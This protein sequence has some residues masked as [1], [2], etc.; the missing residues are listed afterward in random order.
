MKL[1]VIS[2][3]RGCSWAG[4]ETVWHLAT[5]R[6]LNQGH[7]VSA[8]LHPDLKEANE[9]V[10]FRGA[11]GKMRFW[12]PF[13][14]ARFQ[15]LKERILPTFPAGYLDAFDSLL[16]S[17]GSLPALCYVPGLFDGL[18]R[19][20]ARTVLLCQFNAAHLPISVDERGKVGKIIRRSAACL[21]A[22]QRNVD[23]ARRQFAMDPPNVVVLGN[24]VRVILD[25]PMPWPMEEGIIR[26]A[27]VARLET[28]WKGQDILLDI[29]R[30]P[31]WIARD[32]HLTLYG[33][34]PDEQHLRSLVQ[35]F[36]LPDRVT[37]GG[38]VSDLKEIWSKNHLLVMPSHG[39]GLP[40]AA[41]EAMMFGRPVL[42]S[43]VGGNRELV[44][45]GITGFV[46]DAP[47]I[48]SFGDALERAWA[49]RGT[50]AEMGRKAHMVAK[51]IAASNATDK[52]L[53][54]WTG[55]YN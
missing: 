1:A 47:T 27:S 34:G 22:S 35:F 15:N 51:K 32:W 43:D 45:D 3:M 25:Q 50:W 55:S 42:L 31:E 6:A 23:E 13:P 38:F 48:R 4:S 41:L 37:F 17:L 14:I 19:T 44:E 54:I 8:L 30:Q 10:E 5:I 26:F 11:G 40:L 52:L 7:E 18:L 33:S 9:I 36:G 29:L 24:P 16:I 20:S 53:G 12:S 2:N 39:E 46:A 21:F 49:S 28:A